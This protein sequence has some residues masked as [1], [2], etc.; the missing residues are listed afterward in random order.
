MPDGERRDEVD[1][2]AQ[3]AAMNLN[4]GPPER[5]EPLTIGS[6]VPSFTYSPLAQPD[7][8]I[9]LL[10]LKPGIFRADPVDCDLVHFDINSAP[11]YGALSYCWGA[12]PDDR[13]ILC[14]GKVFYARANLERALKRLRAGFRPGEREEY[15]WADAL[16]INQR[17]AAE[18]NHQIRL[19]ERI[20][21]AATTVYIDLGDTS[22][23]EISIGGFT[24]QFGA[25]GGMG[26]PD[27]LTRENGEHPLDFQ[28][29]VQALT[30]PW[31]TR[32]WIIQEIALARV[33][34][35]MF[36]GNIFTEEQLD[37]FLSRNALRAHPER[38]RD[39]T[40]HDTIRNF[41]N[42]NK[43]QQI[44]NHKGKMDSLQLIQLT[45]D[46]DAA[47]PEDKIFGLF[48][49]MSDADREAIGP[50][51][52]SVDQVFRRFAALQVR[53]GRVIG[54]LDSAGLQRRRLQGVNLPSW[55]PDWTAQDTCPAVI[56]TLRPE[57]YWA[58]GSTRPYLWLVGDGTGTGGLSVRG[59][60]ADVIDTV[61]H[62]HSA[63]R[64]SPGGLPDFLVF[65]DRFRA[66]FDELVRQGRARYRDYDRAFARLLLMDDMYT[67]RN[68]ILYSSPIVDPAATYRA[69]LLAWRQRRGFRG[70]VTGQKMD[71]VE[72]FQMQA[73]TT[74]AGRGFATTQRGYIGLVPPVAQVGDL[75]VVIMGATVPH[76]VRKVQSGYL[77]VGDAF[78]HG[79]MY[80]EALRGT[81]IRPVDIVLV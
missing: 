79:Y 73:S 52:R 66:A 1:M 70:S 55:V 23:H 78:V 75:V 69:A 61:A 34:K 28:T 67:G 18:K 31:F 20:Y 15:I 32:T 58:S 30:Q 21:S 43:L 37:S 56:S 80:G 40:R 27:A 11:A 6:N 22:G 10:R 13:K 8:M 50:Y 76:V 39:L 59:V 17:D 47:N 68:A 57:P 48:A 53:R 49:L 16:C 72:T 42:Y 5:T 63:P 29:A 12:P 77:L 4:E 44:K 60:I 36:G 3:L 65:H 14:N 71:P 81:D 51:T 45:R 2:R 33:A 64:V 62:V 54:M 46:F 41:L 35:Y 26:M 38:Q 24:L 74:V 7:S 9:R 19:M 25:L